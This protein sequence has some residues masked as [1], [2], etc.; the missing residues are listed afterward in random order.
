MHFRDTDSSTLVVFNYDTCRYLTETLEVLARTK[1]AQVPD[2]GHVYQFLP[3]NFPAF[4]ARA[5]IVVV[6]SR[7]AISTISRQV[8][9]VIP[10]YKARISGQQVSTNQPQ[11]IDLKT[12]PAA[13]SLSTDLAVRQ[14]EL[15]NTL[16]ALFCKVGV[17]AII[18][19]EG[20]MVD[21]IR[22]C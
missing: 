13:T 10:V 2:T 16:G 22:C 17:P 1:A 14:N 9:K 3:G 18:D 20:R 15:Q 8:P 4:F 7:S 5:S 19:M 11:G 6:L 12:W 21:K